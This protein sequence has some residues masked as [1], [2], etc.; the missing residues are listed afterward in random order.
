MRTRRELVQLPLKYLEKKGF[1]QD[2]YEAAQ[3]EFKKVK[4]HHI[5]TLKG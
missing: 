3:G 1:S 4:I 2:A 5:K